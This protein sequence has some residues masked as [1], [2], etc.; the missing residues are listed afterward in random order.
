LDGLGAHRRRPAPAP[1]GRPLAAARLP[2]RQARLVLPRR[3]ALFEIGELGRLS[4]PGRRQV[5][6]AQHHGFDAGVAEVAGFEPACGSVQA[7]VKALDDRVGLRP[8]GGL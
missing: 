8:V 7:P 2:R 5:G 3:A 4:H 1:T 6:E